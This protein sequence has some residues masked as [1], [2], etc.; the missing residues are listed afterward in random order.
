MFFC[1]NDSE[2]ATET[3]RTRSQEYLAG[4]FPQKSKFEK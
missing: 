1:M 4:R 2:Y 3:D